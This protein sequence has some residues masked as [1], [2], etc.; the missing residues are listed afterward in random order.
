M[1]KETEAAGYWRG[2]IEAWRGSGE[3]QKAYCE[4]QGLKAG[5]FGY[6]H[7]RLAKGAA[8]AQRRSL[9]LVPATLAGGTLPGEAGLY[10]DSP[11][12]WRL[13]FAGLPPAAWLAALLESAA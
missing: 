13:A 1:D 10:L 3:T 8:M 2:H 12:G 7:R 5:S 6:W 9:T 4:R 11:G